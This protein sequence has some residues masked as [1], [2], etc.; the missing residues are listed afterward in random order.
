MVNIAPSCPEREREGVWGGSERRYNGGVKK[1]MF[2]V[3]KV[4][5][6]CQ[7]VCLVGMKLVF[8]INSKFQFYW[9]WKGCIGAKFSL[10]LGELHSGRNFGRAACEACIATCNLG[11][12]SAFAL[13]P[14]KTTENLE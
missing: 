12:N 13:E 10:T 11:T 3:L 8:R 5:R 7:L 4:P 9:N 14:R 6:Q 1:T 2:S